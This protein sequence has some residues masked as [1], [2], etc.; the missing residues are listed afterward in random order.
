MITVVIAD[1]HPVVR[2][3][4]AGMLSAEPDLAVV[5]EASDGAEAV[6]LALKLQ[7]DVVLM[8]LRMP[9][10]DGVSATATLTA[11]APNVHV[12]ILTTYDTDTDIVRAVEAGAVGYLLKTSSREDLSTAVRN[13]ADGQTVLS[14]AAAAALRNQ[15]RRPPH[16]ALTAREQEILSHVATGRTNAEIARRLYIGEATV[17]T[18]LVRIF[19]KLDV[20][21]RTAAVT[22]AVQRGQL[23]ST[24][25]GQGWG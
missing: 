9:G 25:F 12:V 8:D 22:T 23:D 2:T 16:K 3:G 5:G 21:D 10:V 15:A 24:R 13:A 4:L 11:Q 14:P 6:T 17:K 1:D 19:A 7:P 18:H 20:D